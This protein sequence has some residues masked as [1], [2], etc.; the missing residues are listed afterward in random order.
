MASGTKH[1]EEPMQRKLAATPVR[2]L[3]FALANLIEGSACLGRLKCLSGVWRRSTC[4][5][6]PIHAAM[7]ASGAGLDHLLSVA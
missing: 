7:H 2:C 3:D 6:L 4:V 5:A 1:W